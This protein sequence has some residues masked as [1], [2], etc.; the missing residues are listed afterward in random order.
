MRAQPRSGIVRMERKWGIAFALPAI[1]GFVVFV[2]G[3]MVASLVF[4]L[5]DWSIGS[6]FRF[7]G[8]DNYRQMTT[9]DPLFS[10][11]LY[12]TLYYTIGSVPLCMLAAFLVAMLLNQK[13]KALPIFRT[14]YYLPVLV[15]SIANSM[16]WLWLFNPDFGLFNS[17]LRSVGL[18]G[19][20]WIYSETAAIPSLILMSSWGV[21]NAAVIFLAGLQGV[22]RH[23]YEAVEVDGGGALRK[24]WHVTLPSMTPTIFFNVIMGMIGTLQVFD[25]AYVMTNGGP[26]N[27]TLFYIFYLYRKAFAET[28]MAYASAMAWVLFLLIMALT[29]LVF[30]SSRFWVYYEGGNKP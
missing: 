11:S 14:I 26:N 9:G 30:R 25:Q 8:L 21:G 27:A 13:V 4:S 5:T 10:K 12:V 29:A 28:E 1:I 7:V 24:F 20:Q 2:F 3:P 18:P 23:L 19:S 16:L 22:P 17:A 15:P 6:D